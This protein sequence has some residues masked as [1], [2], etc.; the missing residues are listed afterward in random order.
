MFWRDGTVTYHLYVRT[1]AVSAAHLVTVARGMLEPE[2]AAAA[3]P[4]S[5]ADRSGPGR[6]WW[7]AAIL[8]AVLLLLAV[9]L[10]VR[11]PGRTAVNADESAR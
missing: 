11:R 9:V 5:V 2:A 8:V 4:A 10:Y 7:W 1:G 6:P 3:A